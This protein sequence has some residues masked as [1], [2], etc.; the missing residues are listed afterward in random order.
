LGTELRVA[1][2]SLAET[3]TQLEQAR[4]LAV[5]ADMPELLS[6]ILLELGNV[7]AQQGDL[8]G[9]IA[10]FGEM[11]THSHSA[12]ESLQEAIG[13]NNLAYH[14]LL[15]GD[16]ARAQTAAAAGLALAEA[17]DIRPVLQWLYSTHGEIALAEGRWAEAEAWFRRG[18]LEAQRFANA[19]QVI[20]YQANLALVARGRGELGE[21]IAGL[22]AARLSAAALA[23]P[24]LHSQLDLW[25]AE[26]Y[27]EQG[28]SAHASQALERAEVRLHGSEYA[29]LQAWAT[30]VRSALDLAAG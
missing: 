21:A 26:V 15:D 10:S 1:G 13:Y 9:A 19:A 8:A 25:L 11:I 16:L 5:R 22:E 17:R 30:R 4:A 23:D 18:Q 24:Y 7:R 20:T 2:G 12:G 14:A 6:S 27:H 28:A 29:G 3:A